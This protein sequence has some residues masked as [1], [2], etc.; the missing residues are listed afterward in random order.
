[1]DRLAVLKRGAE[2]CC[3]AG[4]L[5]THPAC[6]TCDSASV[7]AAIESCTIWIV[8]G[9]AA[10]VVRAGCWG[11]THSSV[12]FLAHAVWLVRTIIV[13]AA[14]GCMTNV[15]C[16]LRVHVGQ[17]FVVL[18]ACMGTELSPVDMV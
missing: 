14:A 3:V 10:V 4:L 11:W 6:D 16:R 2:A 1:V 13:L 9:L 5:M 17:T 12:A 8:A 7:G 15:L 18:S